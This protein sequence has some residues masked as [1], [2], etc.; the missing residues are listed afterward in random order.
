MSIK[1]LRA[2]DAIH[3]NHDFKRPV[4][5]TFAER[6]QSRVSQKSFAFVELVTPFVQ[7]AEQQRE[8]W[9]AG[10]E[11]SLAWE[12]AKACAM[13]GER[14][15]TIAMA[16]E[17]HA[18][19]QGFFWAD[20]VWKHPFDFY[21]QDE[22][23]FVIESF[24][25]L[26]PPKA[27]YFVDVG[28]FDPFFLSNTRRLINQGWAGL[29][30]EPSPEPAKRLRASAPSNVEVV[31]RAVLAKPGKITLWET[32]WPG[33]PPGGAIACHR[34]EQV[35]VGEWRCPDASWVLGPSKGGEKIILPEPHPVV[36]WADTLDNI[37]GS[38]PF[39]ALGA[40]PHIDLLLMDIETAEEQAFAG[41]SLERYLPT[42]IVTETCTQAMYDRLLN[43]G[44]TLVYRGA[45]DLY[46]ARVP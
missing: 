21:A 36:V 16:Q 35:T 41:F 4:T 8:R 33:M 23:D 24:F 32:D 30:I 42:L 28:A 13:R 22:Q 46:F 9:P 40:G 17:T 12:V 45:A 6:L 39:E 11:W 38:Y 26:V 18:K 29:Q 3:D 2:F 15:S 5:M 31:E 14:V 20:N 19:V 27:K 34:R 43:A 10:V 1:D 25:E 37:L 44:Y 7:L